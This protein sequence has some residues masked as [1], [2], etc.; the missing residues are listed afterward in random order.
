MINLHMRQLKI[1]KKKIKQ[2]QYE[3]DQDFIN[4]T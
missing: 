1:Y 3:G 2:E 4:I